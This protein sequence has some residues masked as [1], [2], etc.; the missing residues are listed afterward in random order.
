MANAPVRMKVESTWSLKEFRSMY[1]GK[2]PQMVSFNGTD[3]DTG[4][5]KSW[6]SIAFTNEDNH[7]T[8]VNFSSKLGELTPAEINSRKNDL[9]VI[10]LKG[11]KYY[12]CENNLSG[13]EFTLNF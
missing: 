8:L 13:E 4:Q 7:V 11:G 6:K 12:L 3:P 10:K 9:N 5:A 2:S 1:D